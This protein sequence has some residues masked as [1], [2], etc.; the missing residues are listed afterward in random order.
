[1]TAIRR[2]IVDQALE[3][4][5]RTA[6][7]AAPRVVLEILPGVFRLPVPA[8]PRP[9]DSEEGGVGQGAA[10]APQNPEAETLGDVL[11][12]IGEPGVL[13]EDVVGTSADAYDPSED[14]PAPYAWA[15]KLICAVTAAMT[16]TG[17]VML[18]I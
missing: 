15:G 6:E 1:M 12:Q 2:R 5:P 7:R 14:Q 8:K 11:V 10:P 17:L 16:A 4:L 18:V 13:R 3:W 9:T